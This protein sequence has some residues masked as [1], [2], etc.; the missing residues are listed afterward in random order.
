MLQLRSWKRAFDRSGTN[1]SFQ[2]VVTGC[3]VGG[4]LILS[5]H[6]LR[7][8]KMAGRS[9]IIVLVFISF[10]FFNPA[11]PLYEWLFSRV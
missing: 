11:I 6:L 2:S 10:T 1:R 5:V 3:C 9:Q 4:K 8:N 7:D